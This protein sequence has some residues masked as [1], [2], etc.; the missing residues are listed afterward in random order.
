MSFKEIRS[1]DALYLL[2]TAEDVIKLRGNCDEPLHR[3][4]GA[5][6]SAKEGA[7]YNG[8]ANYETWDVYSWLSSDETT[9]R[10]VQTIARRGEPGEASE[11]IKHYVEDRNPLSRMRASLYMD[12]LQSALQDVNWYEIAEA[13]RA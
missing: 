10:E 11:N 9:Y 2:H 7:G 3:L 12:L 6:E 5:I 8:W 4:H 13:F 1:N